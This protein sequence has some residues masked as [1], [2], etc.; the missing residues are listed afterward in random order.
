[1]RKIWVI[2]AL[3]S[4]CLICCCAQNEVENKEESPEITEWTTEER[5]PILSW[6]SI[7]L[8]NSSL[9]GYQDLRACGYTHSLATVWGG[10]DS[11]K[12]YTADLLEIALNFAQKVDVKV[13]AGCHELAT[14]PERIVRR[15]KNHPALAG[16]HLKDEPSLIEFE[17]LGN[18][19]KKIKALDDEHF[20]YV[21]L[22]PAD[23]KPEEMGT[24]SYAK[25]VNEYLRLIPVDFVSFDKYPC[26]IDK[27]GRLYV[28]DFWYD[29]LQI[30]ANAAKKS[31]KDFWAFASSVK[32]ESVQATPTIETLRLQ[33]YT[34]LA[35]GAQGLQYFVYQNSTSPVYAA[36]KQMNEEIQNFAKVF[37]GA[38][39]MAVTHTG[40]II[41]VNTKK[42][43][44]A[45]DV[46]KTFETGDVG[47][48][49]SVLEKGNRN[50][51]VVVS[52]DINNELP[53]TIEVDESVRQ[54]T[55]DGTLIKV[56]G[57]VTEKLTPGDI[58]VYTWKNNK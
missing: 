9:K 38:K 17:T 47:A 58:R 29:N 4:T 57:E 12:T 55:K 43:N 18:R 11:L 5:M 14:E 3:L 56:H 37:L 46:I 45:P 35:Y 23:A 20:V 15:F 19:A 28:L 49:V 31:K 6:Y 32:F 54:V 42:F 48:V 44:E 53:V 36:V 22:R 21:N 50:F 16:W 1:M 7:P 13:L 33:M 39:V 26:Q 27:N 24:T 2:G 8:V 30:I 25:Y 52:R 40:K 41:P 51:F 10:E 34:N